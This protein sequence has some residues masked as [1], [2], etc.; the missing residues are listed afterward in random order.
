MIRNILPALSVAVLALLAVLPWGAADTT[1]FALA[2]LPLAAIHYWCARRP[3]LMPAAL[4]FTVGIAMD[5]ATHGPLGFWSLLALVTAAAARLPLQVGR[6]PLARYA[7]FAV[8]MILVASLAW[9]VASLYF[10][11][12]IEWHPMLLAAIAAIAAYPLVALALMPIDRLWDTP[13][14]AIFARGT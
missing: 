3:L 4:V 2:L 11:R 6:G 13:A 14:R 9:A 7:V 8:T 1:R 5:V 10:L 12:G